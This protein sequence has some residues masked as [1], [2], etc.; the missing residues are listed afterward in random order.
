MNE[1]LPEGGQHTGS[2]QYGTTKR[3]T[4]EPQWITKEGNCCDSSLVLLRSA[5]NSGQPPSP[6]EEVP[7]S[8]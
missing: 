7:F 2:H 3:K 1:V 5:V 6:T 4:I 8:I